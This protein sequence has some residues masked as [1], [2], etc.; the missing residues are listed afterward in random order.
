MFQRDANGVWR[1]TL[2]AEAGWIEH[3]FG[4]RFSEIWPPEHAAATR[5]V[6]GDRVLAASA[7]GSCGEGDALITSFADLWVGVRTADCVPILLAN[8]RSLQVAAV[9]AGWRGTVAEVA[10]KALRAMDGAP[11]EVWAAIGPSIGA[12]CYEVGEEVATLF[13]RT[14]RVRL[15]LARENRR[16]LHRA[17]VPLAQMDASDPPCTRCNADFHSFRRDGDKAG[18]MVSAIRLQRDLR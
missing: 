1:S 9:H 10:V 6:H 15:N 2:L 5:Q 11:E 16:Q 12:C 4:G 8:R 7:P 14:G 13:G 3:G 17:G 18:R